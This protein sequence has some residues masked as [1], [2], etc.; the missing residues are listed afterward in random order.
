[1][2]DIKQFLSSVK[3]EII[4]GVKNAMQ[5]MPSQGQE[6]VVQHM[7][8]VIDPE[9]GAKIRTHHPFLHPTKGWRDHSMHVGTN[10][11]RKLTAAGRA[12]VYNV[13]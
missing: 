5:S 10:R 7:G 8:D 13:E 4:E 12:L 1:M 6:I 9:P 3:A 2:P 11:R